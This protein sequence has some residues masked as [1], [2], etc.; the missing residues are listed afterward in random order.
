M[1]RG[2]IIENYINHKFNRLTVIDQYQKFNCGTKRQFVMCRCKCGTVKE[3]R[4]ENVYSG[5]TK[6]CGCILKEISHQTHSLP[7][8]EASF[9]AIYRNYKNNARKDNKDFQL[10]ESQFRILTQQ[11]CNYCGVKPQQVRKQHNHCNGLYLYNGID[12]ID[13][14]LGY[15]IDNVTTCCTICNHAKMDLT[16]NEFEEWLNRITKFRSQ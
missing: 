16:P 3:I 7:K 1:S 5:K 10:T 14:N 9:N 6:S 8:G 15:S 4:F 12:R 13:S 11:N 2:V